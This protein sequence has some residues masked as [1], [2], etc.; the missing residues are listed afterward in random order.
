LKSFLKF[1]VAFATALCLGLGS[2]YSVLWA[3]AESGAANLTSSNPYARAAYAARDLLP[4]GP[5]SDEV[6]P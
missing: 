3:T 5:T 6:H 4:S 2:S 1:V